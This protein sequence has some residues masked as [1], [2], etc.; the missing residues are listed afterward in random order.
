[1][2]SLPLLI[3]LL[4]CP[5]VLSDGI[6]RFNSSLHQSPPSK[7]PSKMSQIQL[8]KKDQVAL[9]EM[10]LALR[11]KTPI[12]QTHDIKLFGQREGG[13]MKLKIDAILEEYGQAVEVFKLN[14]APK[15]E[16]MSWK[17]ARACGDH[18]LLI[19][20]DPKLSSAEKVARVADAVGRLSEPAQ[21]E[22]MEANL[23]DAAQIIQKNGPFL[24]GPA[25][26]S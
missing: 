6:L 14:M 12:E 15:L 24:N 1:M 3:S 7:M 26:L 4:L 5:L 10:L 23:G 25:Y 2:T 16:A 21:K 8:S 11:H 17:E 20:T 18:V 22:L 9:D 19:M 13:L